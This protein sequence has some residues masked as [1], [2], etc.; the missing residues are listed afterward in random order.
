M[1]EF[2]GKKGSVFVSDTNAAGT[3]GFLIGGVVSDTR[4]R[5]D[6]L[7]YNTYDGANP[8][9][10]P[11]S[12]PTSAPVVAECCISFGSVIEEK[13]RE[14]ISGALEWHPTDTLHLTLDGLY[15]RL[16]DPQVAY[17]QAYY[18]DFNY[19]ANGNPE[20]SNV[21]VKN[22]FITS[23]TANTFTP[24]IVNQT[25]ARRVTTALLG[26]NGSWEATSHFTLDADVYQS[27]A[28]RPE[29]GQDAFVTSGLESTTPNNQDIINWRANPSGGLPY[30]SVSLPNGQNYAQALASGELNNNY[31][32]AHYTG[33]NGNSIH[34]KVTGATLDGKLKL[35]D[36]G[37]LTPAALRRG[38]DPA[39]QNRATTSTTTGPGVRASTTSTPRRWA[40]TRSPTAFSAPTSS[41]PPPFRTTCRAR[42]AVS[43]PRW[44]C[45]TS[46][47]C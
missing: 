25:I 16:N 13:K 21:V 11:L 47:T 37:P 3:L 23:F 2:W 28:N 9:V 5:T 43:R 36:A 44:R 38:R 14:A 4:T 33:L 35:D 30:I 10:W 6:S 18:P 1:S 26:L 19:D 12:G 29:G 15:S 39:R 34:D 7:N 41:R 24:E 20:W 22:G 8:G 27:K 40:P 46:R 45:S 42:A 31:W 17:N 32:T